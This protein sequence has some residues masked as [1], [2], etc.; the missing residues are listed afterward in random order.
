MI[1]IS[2]AEAESIVSIC[3]YFKTRILPYANPNSNTGRLD[4]PYTWDIRFLDINGLGLETQDLYTEMALISAGVAFPSGG[5]SV[6][7][8]RDKNPV[9]TRLNLSFKSIRRHRFKP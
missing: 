4:F 7:T 1:P 9:Q 3:N 5:T 6:L 2:Q 8:Y